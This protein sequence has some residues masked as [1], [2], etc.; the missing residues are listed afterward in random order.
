MGKPVYLGKTA[1]VSPRDI[2]GIFDFETSTI[3]KATR[4]YLSQAEKRGEVEDVS[5][6]IPACFTVCIGKKG[7]RKIYLSGKVRF[8]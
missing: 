2:L 6:D 5:S 8:K 1:V 7:E 3:M 4:N